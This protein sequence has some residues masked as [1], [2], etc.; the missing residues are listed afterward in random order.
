ML[1]ADVGV[2][3]HLVHGEALPLAE[4]GP[5]LGDRGETGGVGEGLEGDARLFLAG[6][7]L[8]A[9]EAAVLT[10][11]LICHVTLL[12]FFGHPQTL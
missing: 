10:H 3:G 12:V 4:A 5:S 7:A 11:I 1:G 9:A 8:A 6:V 2:P